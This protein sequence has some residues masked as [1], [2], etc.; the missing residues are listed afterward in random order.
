MAVESTGYPHTNTL[1]HEHAR[2]D[3]E[4]GCLCGKAG[5]S[6]VCDDIPL[7]VWSM[8]M[9]ALWQP[10]PAKSHKMF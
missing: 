3:G 6:H 7:G 5:T 2:G 1:R 4:L 9:A 8:A 10:K